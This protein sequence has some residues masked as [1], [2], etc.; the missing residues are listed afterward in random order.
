MK[1]RYR[2]L[3]LVKIWQAAQKA[4]NQQLKPGF[5]GLADGWGVNMLDACL[6]IADAWEKI[7]CQ[8][9]I[10]CWVAA[11]LLPQRLQGEVRKR[12]NKIGK[13]KSAFHTDSKHA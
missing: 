5:G 7:T 2:T 12:S 9:V 10:N 4:K 8:S 13:R 1:T 3:L 11:N 6:L